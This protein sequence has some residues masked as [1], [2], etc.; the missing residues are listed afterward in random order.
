MLQWITPTLGIAYG[1]YPITDNCVREWTHWSRLFGSVLEHCT[2]KFKSQES[3]G[4]FSAKFAMF[5]S[6]LWL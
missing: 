5:C 6:V 4:S 1:L 3:Q 2:V